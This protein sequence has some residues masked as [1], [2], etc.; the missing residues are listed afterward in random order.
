MHREKDLY[1]DWLDKDTGE[2]GKYLFR[3]L[4]WDDRVPSPKNDDNI[5]M[6]VHDGDMDIIS[7]VREYKDADKVPNP[8][9]YDVIEVQ[10]PWRGNILNI[11][12]PDFRNEGI[13]RRVNFSS[14]GLN[15]RVPFRC[16]TIRLLVVCTYYKNKPFMYSFYDLD[17]EI[18]LG[19]LS[20][21]LIDRVRNEHSLED[22]CNSARG[23][24]RDYDIV[25][26]QDFEVVPFVS[27]TQAEGSKYKIK[28]SLHS[29]DIT[30]YYFV[31]R[32][33]ECCL[34]DKRYS[35]VRTMLVGGDDE[36]CKELEVITSRSVSEVFWRK[37][38]F[39]AFNYMSTGYEYC[40][41]TRS[42]YA[43]LLRLKGNAYFYSRHD[44][45]FS[46]KSIYTITVFSKSTS[47]YWEFKLDTTRY[48][49]NKTTLVVPLT[50]L[51]YT[52]ELKTDAG[53]EIVTYRY[54]RK[55][56]PMLVQSTSNKKE[57]AT[58]SGFI[59]DSWM[60]KP[61]EAQGTED[62]PQIPASLTKAEEKE[63]P[64]PLGYYEDDFDREERVLDMLELAQPMEDDEVPEQTEQSQGTSQ[65]EEAE[66]E[67]QQNEEPVQQE[68]S[69]EVVPTQETQQN[70]EPVQQEPPT[71]VV[72][73]ESVPTEVAPTVPLLDLPSEAEVLP[74]EYEGTIEILDVSYS[75]ILTF[76][77]LNNVDF[78][79]IRDL[80]RYHGRPIHTAVL[81]VICSTF[82]LDLGEISFSVERGGLSLDAAVYREMSMDYVDKSGC[83]KGFSYN[84]IT[85]RSVL[86]CCKVNNF[87]YDDVIAYKESHNCT[88]EDAVGAIDATV[89]NE[90][91][92]EYLS[93]H[94]E[95]LEERVPKPETQ[96]P[97]GSNKKMLFFRGRY[98][99]TLSDLCTDIGLDEYYCTLILNKKKRLKPLSV[100]KLF[101][102]DKECKK[103][104]YDG[105]DYNNLLD[106][107]SKLGIS[108]SV[109]VMAYIK[110]KTPFEETVRVLAEGM[111]ANS[112][113]VK[114][115]AKKKVQ[116][117][118]MEQEPKS[119]N[120]KEFKPVE[121]QNGVKPEVSDL[122]SQVKTIGV[123][124]QKPVTS[125]VKPVISEVKPDKPKPDVS[126]T[127]EV[128]VVLP[129][130][131]VRLDTLNA[132]I[133][134]Y[135]DVICPNAVTFRGIRY[136]DL[137]ALCSALNVPV[138]VFEG[139]TSSEK[140]MEDRLA[141][142]KEQ[143]RLKEVKAVS[144]FSDFNSFKRSTQTTYEDDYYHCGSQKFRS[145]RELC[146]NKGVPQ[147]Y[148]EKHLP[149][150]RGSRDFT[151]IVRKYKRGLYEKNDVAFEYRD[152]KYRSFEDACDVFYITMSEVREYRR[153]N[154]Y[155]TD[156]Q[157]ID[158][159]RRD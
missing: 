12:L 49:S 146:R 102:N 65:E 47:N 56:K 78:N 70:E 42:G 88:Y 91:L 22:T 118:P 16:P 111:G 59:P 108:A 1:V 4:K 90:R 51:C 149:E 27:Y 60:L 44:E 135:Y 124:I 29:E 87:N 72:P 3:K 63:P 19:K 84:Y 126:D 157:V 7:E 86:H 24:Y 141:V 83:R 79:A 156:Q 80:V 158:A 110:S 97:R 131:P 125:G 127:K 100:V 53:V 71:E 48:L 15:A 94:K 132:K 30:A 109:V 89:R 117:K 26:L 92:Q 150:L 66:Q 142:F 64:K 25:S 103:F 82:N 116:P 58:D 43:E 76:C 40:D 140:L 21:F 95:E 133:E 119:E 77:Y 34:Q 32:I 2:T 145:L 54:G 81:E 120:Q 96:I 85:Y 136:R 28:D 105:V 147:N 73:T 46:K 13:V 134:T 98:Y 74:E 143:E 159:L 148:I 10:S 6:V 31:I 62:L 75:D 61:T 36:F 37:N 139:Y 153:R 67:V 128:K 33:K 152:Q 57:D 11:D 115:V 52:S 20:D 45:N 155:A 5:D 8:T 99:D 113:P 104:T 130:H 122:V 106:C 121:P 114:T 35:L 23:F 101:F 38:W 50:S 18:Y 112:L 55:V 137:N 144:T 123:Q 107:C 39:N 14:N 17:N 154:K 69:T 129:I 41:T 138:E 151:S 93:S 9:P 68:Q